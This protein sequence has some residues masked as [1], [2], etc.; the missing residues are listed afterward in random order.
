MKI[1]FQCFKASLGATAVAGILLA[2]SIRPAIGLPVIDD[3]DNIYFWPAEDAP[4]E[5]AWLQCYSHFLFMVLR[6]TVH[7]LG[8]A[9]ILPPNVSA[10]VTSFLLSLDTLFAMTIYLLPKCLEAKVASGVLSNR[11]GGLGNTHASIAVSAIESRAAADN[12]SY[13][14]H[15]NATYDGSSSKGAVGVNHVHSDRDDEDEGK[16]EDF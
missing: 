15:G 13:L 9:E 5:A 12:Q 8:V 11:G 3:P 1:M 14:S 7:F 16:M 10:G 6:A 4:H 2:S